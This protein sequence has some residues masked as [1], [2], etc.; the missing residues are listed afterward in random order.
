M[1]S[2]EMNN[3]AYPSSTEKSALKLPRH[4]AIIMDGNGRWAEKRNLPRVAGHKAGAE[5]VK[6]IVRAA[7]EKKIEALTLWAFSTENWG[8]PKDEV[9][10]LMSL[11]LDMIETA[12]E[13]MHKNN[14]NFRVIGA[15]EKLQVRLQ[16]IIRKAE[17]LT[18]KNTG[19]KLA[20]AIN[21]GGR[22]DLVNAISKL[23]AEISQGKLQICDITEEKIRSLLCLA[24][25][26]EPDLFIRTGGELRL[27]NFLLWQLAYT[28]FYFTDVFW[29]DFNV[30]I[31][32]N[33]LA[34]YA[35][36]KRRFG[37]ISGD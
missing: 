23:A 37:L 30:A 1:K 19:L 32:D 11:F 4:V 33:A 13:E 17:N 34:S 26:P 22:W 7:I 16:E 6:E 3:N 27:S 5:T 29:P 2:A 12:T 20:I 36:R 10:F 9:N 31:L 15:K 25:L 8:R 24:D 18:L 21:Y 35:K 28:E 14:I